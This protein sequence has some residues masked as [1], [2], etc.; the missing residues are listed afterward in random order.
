MFK[1]VLKYLLGPLLRRVRFTFTPFRSQR[2]L[3]QLVSVCDVPVS[4]P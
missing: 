4:S 2:L 3:T 1:G